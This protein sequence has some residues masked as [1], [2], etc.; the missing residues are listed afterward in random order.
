M[1]LQIRRVLV[2][3]P[4]IVLMSSY[5]IEENWNNNLSL[6]E[7][8]TIGNQIW[9]REN[10]DVDH[11]RNGD[12]IPQVQ[13]ADA[14]S[15]LTTG[16]WCYYKNKTENG[17]VYGKLY[18]WYAVNDPRGLAPVGYHVPSDDEWTTLTTYLGGI[19]V[20]GGKMKEAGKAHWKNSKIEGDNSSGFLGLSGG[21]RRYY[22]KFGAN[23]TEGFWWSST[24]YLTAD[25]RCCGLGRNSV[26]AYRDYYFSKKY[27]FSV[28]CL[29][30]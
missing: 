7:M 15:N 4:I 13:D 11:Y 28:R 8:V 2:L 29:K 27:G 22:G 1:K 18:N 3:I 10:L 17:I 19:S 16:A 6:I 12:P 24:E 25:A 9:M 23:G 21:F 5:T 20:A 14:W 30:D 26:S